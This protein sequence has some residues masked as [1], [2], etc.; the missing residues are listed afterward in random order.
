MSIFQAYNNVI[1]K[2]FEVCTECLLR[3]TAA[4]PGVVNFELPIEKHHTN[5][6]NILHGGTIASMVDLGGSLAVAS[7]GLFATGVSTDL[8]VTYL[9]SGGKIG[10]LIR[11]SPVTSVRNPHKKAYATRLLIS[12]SWQD[13]RIHI[14]QLPQRKTGASCKRK[15]HQVCP[16]P[17]RIRQEYASLI[18]ICRYV[19]FAWKD[20]NNIVEEM[21]PKPEKK[22]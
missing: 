14:H 17:P 4:R 18:Q 7:R 20:P 5:R 8:N 11:A 22:E 10:D 9:N 16:P 12:D 19:S 13:T 3:V 6:L 2:V 21:S 15:S 1:P